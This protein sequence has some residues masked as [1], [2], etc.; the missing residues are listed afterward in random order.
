VRILIVEDETKAA[1]Y[2]RRGLEENGFV[3]DL[4]TNGEESRRMERRL[5][6]QSHL[7]VKNSPDSPA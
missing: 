4:A 2:L 6:R 5:P 3:T 1:A 7:K